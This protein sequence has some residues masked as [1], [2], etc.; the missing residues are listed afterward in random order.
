MTSFA[1]ADKA[2]V[3]AFLLAYPGVTAISQL[4][5]TFIGPNQ[6][7]VLARLDIDNDLRADQV[8]SL[9]RGIESGLKQESKNVYRVDVVPIGAEQPPA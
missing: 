8:I 4:L 3:R 2:R 9:V 1:P 6:V 5:V 7:W